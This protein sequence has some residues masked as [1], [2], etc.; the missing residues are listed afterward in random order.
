MTA[1]L[2]PTSLL[3]AGPRRG[4][5]TRRAVRQIALVIVAV[6]FVVA[7]V[8]MLITALKTSGQV[9]TS[10]PVLIPN[11]PMW[12]NFMDALVGHGF[13]RYLLNTTLLSAV[14]A[15]GNLVSASLAAYGLS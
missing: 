2:E 13:A 1:D 15:L 6:V 9:L 14:T 10:P 12:S 7:L 5:R 11:P 3:A 8:W 4:R